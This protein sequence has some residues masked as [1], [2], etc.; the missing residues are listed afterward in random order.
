MVPPIHAV[1]VGIDKYPPPFPQLTSAVS[2]ARKLAD[3][4]K[5]L[6]AEEA[7]IT[8]LEDS[9]ATK[10][11][12]IKSISSLKVKRDD[13]VVF[14]FSG[15]SG[16]TK[17]EDGKSTSVGVICPFDVSVEGGISDKSLLQT[18]DQVS[19]LCGNNIVGGLRIRHSECGSTQCS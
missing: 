2:D 4:L 9:A 3:T 11:Q 14:F 18:F 8:R 5:M 19:K 6:G 17:S 13:A 12:I 10:D 1:I 15:S 16:N 7:N